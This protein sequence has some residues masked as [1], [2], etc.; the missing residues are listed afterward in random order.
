MAKTCGTLPLFPMLPPDQNPAKVTGLARLAAESELVDNGHQVEFRT[1]ATRSILTHSISRRNWGF[2]RS[3][4]PYRGC[5]FG[6]H[7]CYARY[8]HEFMELR[9]SKAF[10]QQIF[11]KQNAAWILRQELRSLRSHE[12]IAIGTATDPYQPIERTAQITR[13][14]LEVLAEQSGLRIGLVTK[15]SLVTRDIDLLKEIAE[16][17]HITVNLTIT[18]LDTSLAR[19]LEPRAPRPDLRLAALSRL[20]DAGLRAGVL[21]CPLLPGITD[22]YAAVDSVAAAAHQA[23]A[24]FFHAEP[25]FLKP[26][27]KAVF[28]GFVARNFPDL[29]ESY[30]NRFGD[31][32]FVSSIYRSRMRE[33]VKA[34][35]EKHGWSP[36]SGNG[37]PRWEQP[38]PLDQMEM[39]CFS[40][41][42]AL[43]PE[44]MQSP[45]LR[46]N[47]IV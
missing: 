33:L 3:I 21:C 18:T 27:S 14:I 31:R 29:L 6:C 5:E 19:M 37:V 12:A 44:Q 8:T 39:Q 43:H 47:A 26:C 38:I 24:L 23:A 1:L 34:V 28:E 7:Y 36:R 10:E 17:N 11:I 20:R 41:D 42:A 30:R 45:E 4:N 40:N 35:K 2:A 22:S 15:S 9:N 32:A 13:G 16:R 25:L 46:R